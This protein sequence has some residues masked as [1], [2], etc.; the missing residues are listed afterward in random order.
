MRLVAIVC[1]SLLCI[2]SC[3]LIEGKHGTV[4]YF[5][6][7]TGTATSVQITVSGGNGIFNEVLTTLP[8]QSEE[9]T[10][11]IDDETTASM[12]ITAVNDTTDNTSVTVE[13]YVDGD[14]KATDTATGPNC[15]AYAD[16]MVDD[17]NL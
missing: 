4:H 3:E 1:M 10:Q 2:T 17:E 13:I 9:W 14:L 8:W 5:Y 15:T 12:G 6:R 11:H 7:V 16:Y